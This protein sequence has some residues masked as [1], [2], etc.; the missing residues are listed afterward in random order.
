MDDKLVAPWEMYEKL[1]PGTLILAN[2][3][4]HCWVIKDPQSKR[5]KK[6]RYLHS[7]ARQTRS[8]LVIAR[9]IKLTPKASVSSLTPTAQSTYRLFPFCLKSRP[10]Q[11]RLPR[12][13]RPNLQMLLR[14]FKYLHRRRRRPLALVAGVSLAEGV[15]S[16]SSQIRYGSICFCYILCHVSL[17]FCLL[18]SY[19]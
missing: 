12:R 15:E 6:V 4:L 2:T 8:N 19:Q 13:L 5:D 17:V 14:H 1:R 11:R 9:F 10:P 16:P 18:C 3:S 7:A